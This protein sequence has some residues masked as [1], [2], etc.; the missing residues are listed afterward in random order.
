MRHYTSRA[1]DPHRH[2]HLQVNARV[3]A[4]GRWRGLHSVG[5]VDSIE[6]LNGIG[7]A[8]VMCDPE[9]RAALAAHGY[10]PRRRH[11]RDRPAR[12]V[13]R[14]VQR[15]RRPRSPGTSTGTRPSGA[16]STPARSPA[17]RC[18]GPGT[19]GPGPRHG[20]T[21]WCPKDGAQLAQRWREE[22]R[23]LGFTPPT[24]PSRVHEAMP[25]GRINRD[26]VADLAL[27]RLGAR[28]SAWNA[29]DIRGEVERIVAAVDVVAAAGGP[30]RAGRGPH[31]P[32]RRRGA[33]RCWPATTCPNT[34]AH[35]PHRRSSRSR[36]TS[37]PGSRPCR[38]AG[39]PLS[40]RRRRRRTPARPSPAAGG[41]RRWPA[42]AAAGRRGRRRGRQDHRPSPPPA[43]CSRCRRVGWWSSPRP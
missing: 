13:R 11:R 4:A 22:L 16:A 5:V 9:F 37:S 42:P 8:A 24:V 26:A 31:Q 21:R 34:S 30:A 41:R 40:G 10:T 27:T 7:H 19:G 38:A 17:R 39:A 43:T 12:A 1:G 33:S 32:R 2:L 20:P 29:A 36:P 35:S 3:F 23:D 14:R 18:G 28:R 6:A 25:I 15:P